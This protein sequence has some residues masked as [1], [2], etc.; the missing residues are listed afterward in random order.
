[1][2]KTP[3]PR[4]FATST[5]PSPSLATATAYTVLLS[6]VP[7]PKTK[8]PMTKGGTLMMAPARLLKSNIM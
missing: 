5:A 3:E 7:G 1:M 6:E 8:R 2:S 4:V